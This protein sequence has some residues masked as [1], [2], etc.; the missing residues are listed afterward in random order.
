[1]GNSIAGDSLLDVRSANQPEKMDGTVIIKML[2]VPFLFVAGE[3][4][5]GS[6]QNSVGLNNW[7]SHTRVEWI[8]TE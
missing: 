6:T 3:R 7:L 8:L 5:T 4:I 2:M 1:M